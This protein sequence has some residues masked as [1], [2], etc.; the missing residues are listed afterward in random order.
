[1]QDSKKIIRHYKI[2]KKIINQVLLIGISCQKKRGR[3]CNAQ[4]CFG[5]GAGAS[6]SGYASFACGQT[7]RPFFNLHPNCSTYGRVRHM[8]RGSK[9]GTYLFGGRVPGLRPKKEDPREGMGPRVAPIPSF[10]FSALSGQR[11]TP[12]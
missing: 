5:C 2:M 7:P 9:V 11:A 4:K 12:S 3:Q 10:F 1:M 6:A 8:P